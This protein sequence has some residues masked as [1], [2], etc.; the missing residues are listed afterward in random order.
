MTRLT[1]LTLATVL[2]T[3]ALPAFANGIQPAPA[4]VPPV[5]VATDTWTGAYVGGSLAYGAFQGT[6]CQE[7][8][9]GASCSEGIDHAVFPVLPEPQ[10]EGATVGITAGYDWQA[11]N[12]VYGVAGDI[13]FGDLVDGVPTAGGFAC[14]AANA[15]QLSISQLTMLRGRVGYAASDRLL[16][17][18]TAGVAFTEV[19]VAFVGLQ[20]DID[21]TATNA[22]I[23]LGADYLATDQIS[24]GF[25]FLH[26]IERPQHLGAGASGNPRVGVTD[27][28]GNILRLNVAYR[29]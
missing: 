26:L 18:L 5:V 1:T 20:P 22:V 11:G 17:Y 29:F 14:G 3:M 4:V 13:M 8:A 19:N 27:F 12:I 7:G 9:L 23:G 2:A 15:C 21:D 28:G 10:P 25:D 6:F 24:V 16:P